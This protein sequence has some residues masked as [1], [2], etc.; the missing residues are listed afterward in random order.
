MSIGD[1]LTESARVKIGKISAPRLDLRESGPL[2]HLTADVGRIFLGNIVKRKMARYSF[3][4]W[5]GPNFD[6]FSCS[7]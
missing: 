5:C 4:A 3:L 6:H 1:D 7:S 2:W